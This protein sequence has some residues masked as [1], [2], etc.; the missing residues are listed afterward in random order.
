MTF[1]AADTSGPRGISPAAKILG[2]AEL[3]AARERA[4]QEGRR[5]VQCHGCFD[6]VHPGHIRHLKYARAQG[7][8][9]LVTLTGDEGV[10]KGTGRPLIPQELR[11]ENLAELDCVDWVHVEQR[12]T[13]VELLGEVQPDIYIKGREYEFNDDARFR[14]EREAVERHGGRVVFS[15]GDVVFSS[16]ALIEALSS[17]LDGGADPYHRRLRHLAEQPGLSP[18]RLGAHIES[19]RGKRVLVVGEVIRDTYIFCDRP[20]IAG[21]S[22][23]MTLRPVEHR[24][25]DGGAAI[26]ARH[27]AQMGARP[28]LVTTL[29]DSEEGEAL[30]ARLTA[31][32]VQI[33]SLTTPHKLAEKQRFLVGG[34]KVMKLDL[35]EPAAM[36]AAERDDFLRLVVDAA[37]GHD[38]AGQDA[39]IVADFGLG[40]LSP[41]V[42]TRVFEALRPRVGILAGSVSGRNGSL[43]SMKKADLIGTTENELRDAMQNQGDGL[44]AVLWGLMAETQ[45]RSAVVTMGAEG[46]IAFSRT[47]VE[48]P[49]DGWTSR[50]R[51]E[52]VP[53]LAPH[54]VDALGCG[55]ALLTAATL[56]L[57]GGADLVASA[58]LGAA[59]ASV[60]ARR[61][62]N[63]A[64][65]AASVRREVL[66]VSS[67]PMAMVSPGV[68][69]TRPVSGR[70]PSREAG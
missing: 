28:T 21:E 23:M 59:A 64:I 8:L 26:I 54:A 51:G 53:S 58:F 31:E 22:P 12:D 39:A 42:I 69:E 52:H 32:G 20:D 3:I 50:L 68:I 33:R 70:L 7:D 25:F 14:A 13:A 30:R 55:D 29:P 61:L 11:A 60:Q 34:T 38:A 67:A 46:L 57:A 44:P 47:G 5:V 63:T 45:T 10:R 36:D 18:Q 17:E 6:I 16:T 62:G 56:S 15:S 9:L 24:R 4:R 66:R 27:A 43:R 49:G 37:S 48:T 1:E 19:W 35:V 65:D 41:G 2:K 40:L